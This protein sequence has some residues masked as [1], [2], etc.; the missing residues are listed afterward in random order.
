MHEASHQRRNAQ[1]LLQHHANTGKHTPMVGGMVWILRLFETETWVKA[2]R[3]GVKTLN[4]SKV[5]VRHDLQFRH[6]PIMPVMRQPIFSVILK[7][8]VTDVG[9]INRS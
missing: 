2:G 9:S 6:S 8:L 1:H 3:Q 4:F 5:I 7:M